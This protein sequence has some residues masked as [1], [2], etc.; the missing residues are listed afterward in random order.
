MNES[1]EKLWATVRS[2]PNELSAELRERGRFMDQLRAV[3][4]NKPTDFGKLDNI[5]SC[6]LESRSALAQSRKST[7]QVLYLVLYN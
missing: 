7:L 6:E 5:L 4:A 1:L 2:Y 3:F